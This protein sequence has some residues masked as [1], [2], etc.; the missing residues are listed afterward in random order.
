MTSEVAPD[1]LAFTSLDEWHAWQWRQQPAL[2]RKWRELRYRADL[3]AVPSVV[4]LWNAQAPRPTVLFALD[5]TSPSH[6]AA[7]VEPLKLLI[8]SGVPV[9]L[10]GKPPADAP[11]GVVAGPDDLKDLTLHAVVSVGSHLA[12][13]AYVRA[14]A[15]RR[16]VPHLVV[17]HGALTPFSPPPE[18]GD[19]VL[20]WSESD[21][22][23]WIAG[24]SGVDSRTVGSQ[25]LWMA[26]QQRNDASRPDHISMPREIVFL[27]QLHGA[28]LPRR[29]TLESVKQLRQETSLTYRPHPAEN[30][31]LSRV[32]HRRWRL[33]GVEVD[34]SASPLPKIGVPVV[35]HFST[36]LLEAAVSGA[37]AFGYCAQAPAWVQG[38]WERYG[39]AEWGSGEETLI[40][41]P[42]REPAEAIVARLLS[43]W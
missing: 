19:I 37:A 22:Q 40:P 17:Q 9:A 2:R 4:T 12:G 21:A 36:G 35:A 43:A 24:R 25:M 15:R 38:F 34:S 16:E 26:S 30:D 20:A 39:I 14:L 27:G 11:W 28:E 10:V 33:R 23:M 8:S 6:L 1:R 29:T 31:L 7:V 3:E 42:S 32:Q 13:G 41:I 5:S 18:D